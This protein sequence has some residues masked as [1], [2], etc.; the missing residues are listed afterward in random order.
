[1]LEICSFS[2][3]LCPNMLVSSTHTPKLF[4]PK[5]A[6]RDARR[7]DKAQGEICQCLLV[8]KAIRTAV[9]GSIRRREA[10]TLYELKK[11]SDTS[12]YNRFQNLKTTVLYCGREK[13]DEISS[14]DKNEKR[15][16][17]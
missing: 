6:E 13:E 11:I 3:Y 16:R 1:M 5:Y 14:S 7:M 17:V 8:S 2:E 9:R 12:K 4:V 10:P 15:E